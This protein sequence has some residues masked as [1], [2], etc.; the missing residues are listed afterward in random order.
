MK[1]LDAPETALLLDAPLTAR[2]G[3]ALERDIATAARAYGR[4]VAR[5]RR[6]R[7]LLKKAEAEVKAHRRTMRLLL[8]ART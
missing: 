8:R 5:V 6:L 1:H 3:K 4:S 2:E 7:A